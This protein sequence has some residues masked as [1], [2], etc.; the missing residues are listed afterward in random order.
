MRVNEVISRCR[1]NQNIFIQCGN[2]HFEGTAYDIINAE[3]FRLSKIGHYLVTNIGVANYSSRSVLY[4]K[5]VKVWNYL[6]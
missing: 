6:L 1:T 3:E 2:M 4:L 5:A